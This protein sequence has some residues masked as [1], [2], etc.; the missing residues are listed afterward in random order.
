MTHIFA[1]CC[2]SFLFVPTV[3]AVHNLNDR[4]RFNSLTIEDNLSQSSVNSIVEDKN[5]YMW[6]ATQ[7]GLNRYDGRVFKH[8]MFAPKEDNSLSSP[9]VTHLYYNS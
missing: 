9:T 2:A 8:V 6:F 4:T 7:D 1:F 5:S 3:E